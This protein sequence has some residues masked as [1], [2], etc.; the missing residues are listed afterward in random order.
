MKIIFAI[1]FV[2]WILPG[3][4]Y[5]Q[6]KYK[7][8]ST[9]TVSQNSNYY[10][11][12]SSHHQVFISSFDGLNIFDG[13]ETKTYRPLTH[14]MAGNN[15]S[16]TFFE[17]SSGIIW[18]TTSEALHHYNPKTDK[19][20]YTMMVNPS[21]DTLRSNHTAF[22]LSGNDLY[23]R[24]GNDIFVFDV[25]KRN[26]KKI[27]PVDFSNTT[28]I[29]II[30][31]HNKTLLFCL[32]PKGYEMYAI[33]DGCQMK[34]VNKAEGV[35]S[36]V[37][38][39]D[40]KT[41]WLGMA[42][43]K[44][45]Q[46][47]PHN[48]HILFQ[49]PLVGIR[50]NGILELSGNRI[51][52]N[53]H[54]NEMIVYDLARDIILDR[55]VPMRAET[56]EAANYLSLPYIDKDSTLWIGG[57]SQSIF[58]FN[59]HKQK[60]QHILNT[61]SDQKP[62]NITKIF[63]LT[64][65]TFLIITRRQGIVMIN[66]K[67]DM[68][69]QWLDLPDGIKNFTSTCATQ[70]GDH[71]FLFSSKDQLYVLDLT[72]GKI[73]KLQPDP[74]YASLNFEQIEKLEN[75][76][77]VASCRKDL[78]LEIQLTDKAFTCRPYG[79]FDDHATLTKQFKADNA[80]NLYVSNDNASV[81]VLRPSQDDQHHRFSYELAIQGGVGS[82]LE[83]K[84]KSGIYLTNTY[85]IF[86]IRH[87]TKEVVQI[88]DKENLLSQSI[89]AAIEDA[90]GNFW[91]SSNMGILKY[92]PEANSVK[93]YSRMDGVQAEEFN[94]HAYLETEDGHIFF[95]GINGLNYFHPDQVVTFTREAPVYIRSVK[96]NDEPDTAIVVPEFRDKYLLPYSRNTI[97]FD[98]H[99]IDYADPDATRVKY[100]LVGV[101]PEFVESQSA[102][103]FARYA[104]LRYGTYT[105]LLLGANADGHWNKSPRAIEI[106][107]QPPFYLTWWFMTLC[108]LL[109]VGMMYGAVR[110][111]FQR[112]LERRNQVV[113]EQALIIEKQRALEH[114]RNRIA[115]EMHDDLGSGLTT[116]RYLSDRALKQAKDADEANQIKR[117][118][119]HSK[120]LVRNMS[121]IIWAMN[122]RFDTAENL[123]G[124]LRRYASEYLEEHQ[125]PLKFVSRADHMDK[126]S[127]GAEKRRNVFLVF[128]EM[129]HNAV[130]YSGAE[131]LEIEINTN[132]QLHIHIAEIGGKGFDPQMATDKGNGLFNCRKRMYTAGGALTFEKT[133]EAMHIHIVVPL[134]PPTGE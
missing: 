102:K 120:R 95:G 21:G 118:S 129:L 104:N 128:K 32:S 23:L 94:S 12:N 75:G 10:I 124:Y 108:F 33:D 54:P 50:I 80:G 78:L 51:L 119:E 61:G 7:Y 58:F 22:L 98:F 123:V 66:E 130:K 84:T 57:A 46:L 117:I 106:I 85:G 71:L 53:V 45:M 68:L 131:R 122:S 111:Y 18:F 56:K 49:S 86:Y 24:A 87:D 133:A 64:A 15:M 82:L 43:G 69:Q 17:D 36:F 100:K 65:H 88:M 16:G 109:A 103:G 74:S 11:Y 38:W 73:K 30:Q 121:E 47:D 76:K 37:Y 91:L 52:V 125:L 35:L 83:D 115:T 110:L 59:L 63:S 4:A 126:V 99:A 8:C 77:I 14:H 112:K 39:S 28:P 67:G 114:E 25:A 29:D 26:I 34:W 48:G 90:A 3:H 2:L 41:F 107:I 5:S 105:L 6:A 72:S 55:F 93:V 27:I 44:L 31:D 13:Q 81:L 89:Y 127:I 97:S 1:A 92:N 101:D 134:N 62:F 79:Y 19:L 113:R 42:D 20:D 40:S 96:I 116:I 70:I 9:I 132:H 60:F